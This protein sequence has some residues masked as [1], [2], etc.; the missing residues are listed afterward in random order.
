[1]EAMYQVD[2]A[3]WHNNNK[4]KGFYSN[5]LK[6]SASILIF[7]GNIRFDAA[8]WVHLRTGSASGTG[9]TTS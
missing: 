2:G 3:D 1:M 8:K 4:E 5:I 6:D 7:C 9:A